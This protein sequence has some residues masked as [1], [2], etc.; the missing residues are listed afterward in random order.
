MIG[1]H[2]HMD[3][4]RSFLFAI[5]LLVGC[6]DDSGSDGSAGTS[7]ISGTGGGG[8]GGTGGGSAGGASAGIGGT[9]GG[10]GTGGSGGMPVLTVQECIAM[11]SSAMPMALATCAPCLCAVDTGVGHCNA[12]CWALIACAGA[13][14]G[15][16]P[17]AEQPGCVTT[18]CGAQI[19]QPGAALGARTLAQATS[20]CTAE[21]ERTTSAGNAGP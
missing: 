11:T 1:T 2:S 4:V 12:N 7:A 8:T 18:M 3:H 5:A 21:C 13:T 14:C 6:G 9:G 19:A 15:E 17:E 20:M 16:V 10:V